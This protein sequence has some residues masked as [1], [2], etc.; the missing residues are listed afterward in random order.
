[1]DIAGGKAIAELKTDL[2][3]MKLKEAAKDP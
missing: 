2:N 3:K 1:M